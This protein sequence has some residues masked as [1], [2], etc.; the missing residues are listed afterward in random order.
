[1]EK[2]YLVKS[3]FEMWGKSNGRS[4]SAWEGEQLALVVVIQDLSGMLGNQREQ[5]EEKD[6]LSQHGARPCGR[7]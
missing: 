3:W 2:F 1:M 6:E 4:T 5:E 7:G